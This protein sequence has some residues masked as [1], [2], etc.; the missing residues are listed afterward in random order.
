MNASVVGWATLLT[1]SLPDSAR[2]S[3]AC[4]PGRA[5]GGVAGTA[6]SLS[7][8]RAP[9]VQDTFRSTEMSLKVRDFAAAQP[10]VLPQMRH[11]RGTD[12]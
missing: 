1:C 2:H 11:Y 10:R 12:V 7:Y 6:R 4:A 9:E 3:F 8:L 5:R